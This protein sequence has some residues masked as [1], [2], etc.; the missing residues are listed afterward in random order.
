VGFGDIHDQLP[1]VLV[2]IPGVFVR[3]FGE[4]VSGQ[5][6]SFAMGRGSGGVGV[7]RKVMQFCGLIV[8]TL[9][10]GVLLVTQMVEG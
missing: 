9:W 3:L 10:H 5:M 2:S 6:I 1:G 4:F 8:S 7:G